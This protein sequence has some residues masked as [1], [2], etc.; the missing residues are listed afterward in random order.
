MHLW[1]VS[2]SQCFDADV[3]PVVITL[4]QISAE[5]LKEYDFFV[6]TKTG[7]LL[8]YDSNSLETLPENIWGF[9]L[10]DKFSLVKKLINASDSLLSVCKIN[11]TSTAGEADK[12]HDF[13]SLSNTRGLKLINTGTID[14]YT[15]LWG[16]RDL[17]DKGCKYSTPYLQNSKDLL[18]EYR[19][20]MY[21]APKI[22]F[23]KIANCTEAFLDDKGEYSSINTNCLYDFK[24]S[25]HFIL[26]WV[27]SSVFNFIYEVFFAA[28]ILSTRAII[29]AC[30]VLLIF[31]MYIQE[32]YGAE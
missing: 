23:A 10:S 4:R 27:H 2:D 32:R 22:I 18:G 12:F 19:Y 14:P 11:A 30:W 9:L 7:N 5:K 29:G 26:G 13:I 31:G 3:Y 21:N 6:L 24:I 15:S 16:N 20:M 8:K 25:S 28:S 1:D 17:I